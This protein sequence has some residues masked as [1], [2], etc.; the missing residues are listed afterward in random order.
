[1]QTLEITPT[2]N[3]L[4]QGCIR[5]LKTHSLPSG[6]MRIVENDYCGNPFSVFY[7]LQ[8]GRV[9]A[10]EITDLKSFEGEHVSFQKWA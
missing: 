3:E 10:I 8:K 9:M 6:L 1:M 4:K 2:W 7:L 5:D